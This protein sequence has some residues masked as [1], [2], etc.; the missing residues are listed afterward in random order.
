[1]SSQLIDDLLFEVNCAVF[2]AIDA[3]LNEQ[4]GMNRKTWIQNQ[5]LPR[6]IPA[7]ESATQAAM[8]DAGIG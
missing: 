5:H 6:L 2:R 4:L 1:M 8:R 3:T 7:I